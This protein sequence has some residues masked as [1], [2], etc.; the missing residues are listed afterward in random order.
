MF[1][2][3]FEAINYTYFFVSAVLFLVGINTGPIVVEKNIQWLMAYPLLMKRLM[4]RYFKT[5]RAFIILFFII[6]ILNNLSLF[7]SFLSG[8]LV[9]LPPFAAFVTGLNV[10]IISFELMGWKGIWQIL[11]N[12]V[13]WLEFPAAWLSFAMGFRLA[14]TIIT[15]HSFHFAID[16][17]TFLLLMYFKYV[18]TLLFIAALLEA[19]MIVFAEKLNNGN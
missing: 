17:F 10:S 2:E 5:K 13:A 4:D 14:E 18:L 1:S 8:F 11:V 16:E 3:L 15:R 7:T 6:F 12:P 19:A 9:V